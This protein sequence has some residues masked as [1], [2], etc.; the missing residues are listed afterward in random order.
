M[1]NYIKFLT[2]V[3]CAA[4]F[5][6]C[7]DL[8]EEEVFGQITTTNTTENVAEGILNGVY[9]LSQSQADE[10]QRL[11]LANEI[12]T[13]I[14]FN[15]GGGLENLNRPYQDFTW[16]PEDIYLIRNIYLHQFRIIAQANQAL[17]FIPQ[18]PLDEDKIDLFTSEAKFLRA[19]AFHN[20]E[21]LYGPVPLDTVFLA[22]ESALSTRPSQMEM[23]NFIRK[24]YRLAAEVLP[25]EP[26]VYGRAT[27]GAAWPCSCVL[28]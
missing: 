2:V 14:M 27:K 6:N 24:E 10:S 15:Q 11:M 5:W 13:D 1:K 23:E 4:F 3:S 28:S 22:N 26:E 21:D 8:L 9:Q 17:E 25:V 7:E 18:S 12:T 20:L 19:L 16:A